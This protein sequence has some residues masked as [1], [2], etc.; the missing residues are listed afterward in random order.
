MRVNRNKKILFTSGSGVYG[1]VPDSPV[2]ENYDEMI[3]SLH[4]EVANSLANL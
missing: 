4:M 3:L 2:T 1:E